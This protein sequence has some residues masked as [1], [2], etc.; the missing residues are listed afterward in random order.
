[1]S[2]EE[3]DL[4]VYEAGIWDDVD[5]IVNNRKISVKSAAHFSQLLLLE[6]DD[7]DEHGYYIPNNQ[8]DG[9][10]KAYRNRYS[11]HLVQS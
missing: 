10:L 11:F 3:P 5:L 1:M 2:I 9:K 8:G 4:G 6:A 7:W